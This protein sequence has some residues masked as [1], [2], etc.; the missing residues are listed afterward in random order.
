MQELDSVEATVRAVELGLGAAFLPRVAVQRELDR[1]NLAAV[2]LD[3]P[4]PL[5]SHI[6]AVLNPAKYRPK[7]VQMLLHNLCPAAFPEPANA[8]GGAET[9]A[10]A[11]ETG[12]R[13]KDAS[14]NG[15]KDKSSQNGTSAAAG[16]AVAAAASFGAASGAARGASSGQGILAGAVSGAASGAAAGT[17]AVMSAGNGLSRR[18][19]LLQHEAQQRLH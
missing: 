2:P 1:G 19:V 13:R 15:A 16:A 12:A 18:P 14:Q 3:F 9:C 7:A 11:D 8:L 6:S 10:S 5:T 4:S 17:T